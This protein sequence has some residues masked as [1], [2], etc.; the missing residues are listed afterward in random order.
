MQYTI[1]QKTIIYGLTYTFSTAYLH[2]FDYV[3]QNYDTLFQLPFSVTSSTRLTINPFKNTIY[4]CYHPGIIY[5]LNIDST[6]SYFV[7]D[8][9]S[10]INGSI[11]ELQYDYFTNCLVFEDN[12]TVRKY[13]LNTHNLDLIT[14]VY[15]IGA[16][17]SAQPTSAFNQKFQNF[18]A[19]NIIDYGGYNFQYY[20]I[21]VDCINN[22]IIDT[23]NFTSNSR[24]GGLTY[25]LTDNQYYAYNYNQKRVIQI[26]PLTGIQTTICNFNYIS[27]YNSQQPAFD[28]N[29]NNYLFPFYPGSNKLAI[30]NVN[31]GNIDTIDF[32]SFS[33]QLFFGGRNP[34]LKRVNSYLLGSYSDNYT[35]YLNG[36]IIMDSI[37]QTFYPT[38]DGYYKIST[39]IG[40]NTYF[41]NEIYLSVSSINEVNQNCTIKP[42]PAINNL[43][44][45]TPYRDL[46][47]S[48]YNIN[49]KQLLNQELKGNENEIN[50]S[51]FSKGIY[52]L[53]IITDNG[54]GIKKFIKE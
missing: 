33:Y 30:I 17:S 52:I 54:I 39:N 46:M 25:N 28:Y 13:N 9:S 15:Q 18:Y 50:I 34:L 23:I 48:I 37:S 12:S 11:S 42:N 20:S 7:A 38:M 49:G 29:N 1:A 43:I 32:H 44:I 14:N 47:I 2:S 31:N 53:K 51:S 4:I 22:V 8:L 3:N 6:Y 35:W 21:L 41:S 27:S 19:L 5:A 16:T 36:N 24:F 10:Q 26:S 40:N 45:T